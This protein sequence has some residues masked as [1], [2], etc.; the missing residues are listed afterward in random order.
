MAVILGFNEMG[1][2][3][4]YGGR[5]IGFWCRNL[6]V[7]VDGGIKGMILEGLKWQ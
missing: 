2:S 4:Y 7:G 5:R 1:R 3:N 6:I